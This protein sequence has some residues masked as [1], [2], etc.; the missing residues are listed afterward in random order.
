MNYAA[1]IPL[2]IGIILVII[3]WRGSMPNVW[4]M[5]TG[6]APAAHKA[7]MLVAPSTFLPF[8]GLT[9]TQQQAAIQQAN[10]SPSVPITQQPV[11][12]PNNQAVPTPF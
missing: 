2:A 4:N 9:P 11:Q 10:G 12:Q 8:T 7:G 3:G 5:L 6:H 1:L